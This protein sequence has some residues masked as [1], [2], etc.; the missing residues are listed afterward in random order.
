MQKY[1]GF[2]KYGKRFKQTIL[3]LLAF[4]LVFSGVAPST[5]LQTVHA[6]TASSTNTAVTQAKNKMLT[7]KFDEFSRDTI[8]Q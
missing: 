1:F 3:S 5:V 6:E 7:Y 2:K 8:S 4:L